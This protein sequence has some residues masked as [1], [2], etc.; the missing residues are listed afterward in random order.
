MTLQKGKGDIISN[1]KT[2]KINI[3]GE[4][5]LAVSGSEDT[6]SGCIGGFCCIK[7]NPLECA[8]AGMFIFGRAGDR[9]FGNKG[10]SLEPIDIIEELDDII[11]EIEV[12]DTI[13]VVRLSKK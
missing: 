2:K 13:D 7:K 5:T 6:L 4:S 12:Y 3:A 11:S 10:Y 9:V 8:M 1:G